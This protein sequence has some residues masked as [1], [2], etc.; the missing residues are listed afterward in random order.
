MRRLLFISTYIL[1]STILLDAQSVTDTIAIEEVRIVA[2][3][4]FIKEEAGQKFRM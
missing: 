3:R 4:I 2:N 1:S